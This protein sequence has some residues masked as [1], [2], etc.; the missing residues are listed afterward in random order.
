MNEDLLGV[1]FSFLSPKDLMNCLGVSKEWRAEASNALVSI[2][3]ERRSMKIPLYTTEQFLKRLKQ[4]VSQV[5]LNQI[6][7]VKAMSFNGIAKLEV[8]FEYRNWM[9]SSLKDWSGK[10]IQFNAILD[11]VCTKNDEVMIY[12]ESKGDESISAYGG[13][14]SLQRIYHVCYRIT[15]SAAFGDFSERIKEIF[16]EQTAQF[17]DLER[18]RVQRRHYMKTAAAISLFA[19]ALFGYLEQI[20]FF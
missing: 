4:C 8:F 2:V 13:L 20:A 19:G 15:G 16:N 9:P 17:H 6:L 1:V 14:L 11:E 12:A 3:V 7:R 18:K 5:K 10:K